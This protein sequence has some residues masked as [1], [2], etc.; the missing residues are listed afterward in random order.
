M[1]LTLRH[2][3][4][5]ITKRTGLDMYDENLTYVCLLFLIQLLLSIGSSQGG[6]FNDRQGR[7]ISGSMIKLHRSPGYYN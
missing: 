6:L 3:H 1:Q 5:V 2:P 7:Q 4:G